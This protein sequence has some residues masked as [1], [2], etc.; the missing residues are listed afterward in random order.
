MLRLLIALIATAF[1]VLWKLTLFSS[2]ILF[3]LRVGRLRTTMPG[4]LIFIRIRLYRN[5]DIRTEE[6]GLQ[7]AVYKAN[8]NQEPFIT[9]LR[10]SPYNCRSIFF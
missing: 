8:R 9:V 2:S 3:T 5:Y 1:A 10:I 6:A 7:L 4:F